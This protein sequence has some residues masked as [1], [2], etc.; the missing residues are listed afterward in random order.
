MKI[1]V[2]LLEK[3]FDLADF[4]LCAGAG[5]KGI[6][7]LIVTADDLLARCF[8][9]YFVIND[10]V[11]CHVN[12]HICRRFIRAA[13]HDLLKHCLYNREN[14]YITVVVNCCF[15]VGFQ[16][17]RIDH[18]D[19]HLLRVYIRGRAGKGRWPFFHFQVR[20]L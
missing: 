3:E 17:E 13:A 6:H 12:T 16:M 19:R 15:A 2:S 10:A 18:I 11:S 8:L 20:E 4:V 5:N 1:C 9:A 7:A 14:F